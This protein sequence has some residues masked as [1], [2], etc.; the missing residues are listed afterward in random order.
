VTDI[1]P[2]PPATQ[3]PAGW[4]DDGSGRQ[5]WFDGNQWTDHFTPA[6]AHTTGPMTAAALN[7]NRQVSYVRQQQGHSI[8]LHIFLAFVIVGFFTIPYYSLS[9]NHYW[10]A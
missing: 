4:Y 6:A 10:H 3:P 5:R 7:V 9:P 8:I 1:T 2:P